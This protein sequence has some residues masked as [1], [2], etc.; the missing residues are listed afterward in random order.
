MKDLPALIDTDPET[1]EKQPEKEKLTIAFRYHNLSSKE[2]IVKQ[3]FGHY[4]DLSRQMPES[5]IKEIDITYW[6]GCSNPSNASG[7]N[8]PEFLQL[9]EPLK[10]KL[11]ESYQMS[12]PKSVL[13][14]AV[15]SLGSPLWL[16][17]QDDPTKLK[18]DLNLF[19]YALR[20][21]MRSHS[22]VALV[23]VPSHLYE[24]VVVYIDPIIFYNHFFL[25]F[26]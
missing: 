5:K 9:L 15:H 20:G 11:N 14:V 1:D 25:G 12:N 24:E 13:R 10:Y 4:Y 26:L 17:T 16:T 18:S 22:A 3:H 19:F 21:L 8:N 23:T 2:E 6:N 7:F